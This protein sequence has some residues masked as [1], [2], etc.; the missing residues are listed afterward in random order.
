MEL[1]ELV[2]KDNKLYKAHLRE[3]SFE[4][5]Q[6]TAEQVQATAVGLPQIRTLAIDSAEGVTKLINLL[7]QCILPSNADAYAR[8][9]LMHIQDSRNMPVRTVV[10]IQFYRLI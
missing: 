8:G 2:I 10:A 5:V 1:T 6:A 3:S 9:N 4:Q 7:E